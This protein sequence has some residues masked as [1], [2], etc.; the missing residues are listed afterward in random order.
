[1]EA[2]LEGIEFVQVEDAGGLEGDSG[3][4]QTPEY[5]GPGGFTSRASL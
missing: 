1:M 4:A 3:S 2:T 5:L